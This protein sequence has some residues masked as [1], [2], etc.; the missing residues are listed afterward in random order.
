MCIQSNFNFRISA[1]AHF[2][3]FCVAARRL[4]LAND[5]E[6]KTYGTSY[7]RQQRPAI[8][9]LHALYLLSTYLWA[10][11]S[12]HTVPTCTVPTVNLPMGISLPPYCTYMHCTYCQLT[13]GHQP[14]TILY[15]HALYLLSTYLWASASHHTVRMCKISSS[16]L[17]YLL[18]YRLTKKKH[19]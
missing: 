8:L 15:L 2:H 7:L 11:A 9:Y 3:H 12:R 5:Y 16:D 6:S 13:Y 1:F 19:Y 18:I 4:A 17:I 14:P 10:S